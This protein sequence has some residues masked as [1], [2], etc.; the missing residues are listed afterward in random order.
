[1]LLRLTRWTHAGALCNAP[2]TKATIF[3]NSER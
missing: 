3:G 1:M 2:E